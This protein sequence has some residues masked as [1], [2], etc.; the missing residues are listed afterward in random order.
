MNLYRVS[1]LVGWVVILAAACAALAANAF[2]AS[3][4]ANWN[5]QQVAVNADDNNSFLLR[6]GQIL[7]AP[8]DAIDVGRVLTGSGW[9]RTDTRAY[10]ITLFQKAPEKPETAA[11]EV[12]DTIAKVRTATA[13][14][15]Q[16]PARVAPNHVFVGESIT[17]TDAI[18]FMGEPRIQGGPGSSV[19]LAS[20]PKE[21]PSRG[22]LPGDGKGAKIAVLDTGMFEHE[23]L[24]SVQRAPLSDD[25]WD[26]E[27]DGYGDNESGHGTFIAGLIRQVAP[28]ASIYAVK[29]L[30]SHGV[31][32]DLT[33]AT[34]MSQL[35]ADV[36]IVNLSLGGYTE[37]NQPPMA[38]A[39]AM[40]AWQNKHRVVVAAAGNHADKRPFWPAAF[41]PVV[42]VG[43]I[44]DR[45]GVFAPASFS[46]YGDWVDL[47]AR[48]AGLQST[49]ARETTKVATGPT[50]SK[51]DPSITFEG[52][53]EWD[54]TS[55]STPIAAAMIARTMT[56]AGLLSAADASHKL[57]VSAPLS[58]LAPFP[59]ARLLDEFR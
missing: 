56:R 37:G 48:G 19:E 25:V 7:V 3:L 55:F 14:R 53:A 29:V 47:V 46:N 5:P 21:L 8:G 16:G 42:S 32:D 15:P 45:E 44:E 31:G 41:G 28:A 40:Q 54:G 9:K 22:A 26:V 20:L 6:P 2:A 52:W 23:W 57:H 17:S 24:R 36:N 58:G 38:I 13:Y 34:A 49:F 39:T 33:V 43:A 1:A 10:G 51:S 12:L 18:N 35:P 30:D 59:Y 11:R 50:P 4:P 27:G